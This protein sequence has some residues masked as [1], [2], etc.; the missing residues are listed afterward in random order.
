MQPSVAVV[1]DARQPINSVI[2]KLDRSD[3]SNRTKRKRVEE[4]LWSD[5]E[6]ETV[7]G[8]VIDRLD[9]KKCDG[10]SVWID[11]INPFALLVE[12]A[13]R[14]LSFFLLMQPQYLVLMQKPNCLQRRM[15]WSKRQ[16]S[17]LVLA[18]MLLHCLLL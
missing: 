10:A 7:Y 2:E 17:L 18:S 12:A 8:K 6:T 13:S 4:S 5:A 14:S 15:G 16:V 9:V 11:F 3:T 1:L